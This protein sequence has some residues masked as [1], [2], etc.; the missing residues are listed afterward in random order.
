[1]FVMSSV[2][3]KRKKTKKKSRK[4]LVT[5]SRALD[6]DEVLA[7]VDKDNASEPDPDLPP[8]TD[9]SSAAEEAVATSETFVSEIWN[10]AVKALP[11]TLR[12]ACQAHKANPS[13]DPS[14]V[15]V[16]L[17]RMRL[18]HG[19]QKRMA[20][21]KQQNIELAQD[22]YSRWQFNTK[23]VEAGGD[24]LI[25]SKAGAEPDLLK[26][27]IAAGA[28]PD[29][30][31]ELAMGMSKAANKA[32]RSLANLKL[33]K[34]KRVQGRAGTGANAGYVHLSYG[35]HSVRIIKEHYDKLH[36]LFQRTCLTTP[37]EDAFRAHALTLLLRYSGFYGQYTE[38]AG[39]QAAI[40][41]EVFDVLLKHFDVRFECFASPFNA[42][43][44]NYCSAFLDT[45][46]VF[47][48]RG[49]FF[50]FR[51][52]E[53]CFEA[54]P[55]FIPKLM[56]A[57]CAHME[58]L[59]QSTNKAL[60][61]VVIIPAWE[62]RPG[63][64]RLHRCPYMRHHIKV[65]AKQHGYTEGAQHLRRTRFRISTCDTSIFFLFNQKAIKKWPITVSMEKS[66]CHAFRSQHATQRHRLFLG[67]FSAKL[68]AH[69][70]RKALVEAFFSKYGKV[71]DV[72]F[73]TNRKT[74]K[75]SGFC[76][77]TLRDQEALETALEELEPGPISIGGH[78]VQTVSRVKDGEEGEDKQE[79][80]QHEG[81]EGGTESGDGDT[82]NSNASDDINAEEDEG[83]DEGDD[84]VVDDIPGADKRK[85]AKVGA[86]EQLLGWLDTSESM[87]SDDDDHHLLGWLGADP[88]AM[89]PSDQQP[90]VQKKKKKKTGKLRREGK[91]KDA[92]AFATTKR[93]KKTKSKAMDG[94]KPNGRGKS[95]GKNK[96]KS[97]NKSKSK[98][99]RSEERAD[100]ASKKRRV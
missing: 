59:L 4:S 19:L 67:G 45:D 47:G 10:P 53:G 34:P 5:L 30:A 20:N 79:E 31:Q 18:A 7:L 24:P 27:L 6:L 39:F 58:E 13:V 65:A 61:F 69:V 25:P 55:P 70:D 40:S 32:L 15:P 62:D 86:E 54:N 100:R 9:A 8:A 83:E 74:G 46:A 21:L 57:M 2:G 26:E 12:A 89:I 97:K 52:K 16:E 72:Y 56:V 50:A 92:K 80:D 88:R 63:W 99:K 81:E 68:V 29:Q 17:A 93:N 35:K 85:K 64:A 76:F 87:Q 60:G 75:S 51:P 91:A 36:Q 66:L 41:G 90:K 95:S 82:A 42:R 77:V 11:S 98:S 71:K 84:V 73:P 49:S 43:Y 33:G 22:A 48:S 38:G 37:S 94:D 23:L 1:M 28:Q 3:I 96:N 44:G 78:A 14:A